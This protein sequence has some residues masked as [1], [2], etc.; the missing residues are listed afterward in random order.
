M[1]V[2][3]LV[4]LPE[5]CT[6]VAVCCI[7]VRNLWT[8]DMSVP[9]RQRREMLILTQTEWKMASCCVFKMVSVNA[10]MQAVQTQR[11][12][13][14][15]SPD[16]IKTSC[17]GNGKHHHHLHFLKPRVSV[18]VGLSC[19]ALSRLSLSLPQCCVFCNAL[20]KGCLALGLSVAILRACDAVWCYMS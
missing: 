18:T 14:T 15:S 3:F 10:V 6:H 16:I 1:R 11:F 17:Y 13:F 5:L 4:P 19:S 7:S 20:D 12:A 8:S 2:P 9:W